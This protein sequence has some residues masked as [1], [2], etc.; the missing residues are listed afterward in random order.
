MIAAVNSKMRRRS[1]GLPRAER[2]AR[3][4]LPHPGRGGSRGYS[5]SHRMHILGL[6]DDGF[7]NIPGDPRLLAASDSSIN[8][9]NQI[10][11]PFL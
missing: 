1:L 3:L 4:F 5:V 10:L 11:T 6:H 8:R 9:W 2:E 7:R